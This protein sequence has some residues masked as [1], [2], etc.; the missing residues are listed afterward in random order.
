MLA[1]IR[2]RRII[3]LPAFPARSASGHG[4]KGGMPQHSIRR[5]LRGQRR[6]GVPVHLANP[7]LLPVE[8]RPQK[9]DLEHQQAPIVMSATRRKSFIRSNRARLR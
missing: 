5:P 2:A 4:G 8:L 6:F 9:S 7:S 1:G 3:L